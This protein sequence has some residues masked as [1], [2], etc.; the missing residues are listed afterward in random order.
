MALMFSPLT[1]GEVIEEMK[2]HLNCTWSQETVDT[3]KSGDPF[4]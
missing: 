2:A 4:E 1:A 3:F